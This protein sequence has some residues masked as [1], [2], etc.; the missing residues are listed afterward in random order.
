MRAYTIYTHI[1]PTPIRFVGFSPADGG[2]TSHDNSGWTDTRGNSV[3]KIVDDEVGTEHA[4]ILSQAYCGDDTPDRDGFLQ[5]MLSQGVRH[6]VASAV[7]DSV[8]PAANP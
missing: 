8:T 4:D 1:N 7:C 2:F 3:S 6:D 5:W